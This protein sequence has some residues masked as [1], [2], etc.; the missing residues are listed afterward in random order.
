[1]LGDSARTGKTTSAEMTK[2]GTK[3]SR[4]GSTNAENVAQHVAHHLKHAASHY[5]RVTAPLDE[6]RKAAI[7]LGKTKQKFRRLRRDVRHLRKI[8]KQKAQ[9]YLSQGN[10]LAEGADVDL[11]EGNPCSLSFSF[12][13]IVCRHIKRVKRKINS[14]K[15]FLVK[16]KRKMA[17]AARA[18]TKAAKR[19][20]TMLVKAAKAAANMIKNGFG[21]IGKMLSNKPIM[22]TAGGYKFELQ[23][24]NPKTILAAITR[25][26][27]LIWARTKISTRAIAW[28]SV[29]TLEAQLVNPVCNI[30]AANKE[31]SKGH[32]SKTSTPIP[33]IST[34]EVN[35]EGQ[36][37]C[38][39]HFPAA[40]IALS[41]IVHCPLAPYQYKMSGVTFSND[42]CL[43][44]KSCSGSVL[45]TKIKG[46]QGARAHKHAE[47]LCSMY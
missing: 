10:R 26:M 34:P 29:R 6:V 28:E 37:K 38:I 1:M 18:V 47:G 41:K 40:R 12:V 30:Q 2:T 9:V 13:K 5:S 19:A 15:N 25:S 16:L 31:C 46:K 8:A 24:F 42:G 3:R 7:A 33:Q 22:V 11:K 14:V 43:V 21:N 27:A 45:Q 23:I 4:L 17:K 32:S 20:A 39:K 35:L 44:D 36:H